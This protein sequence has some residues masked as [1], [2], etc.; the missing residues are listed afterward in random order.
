MATLAAVVD[1]VVMLEEAV[2]LAAM[3]EPDENWE[4]VLGAEAEGPTVGL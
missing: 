1:L 4:G 2:G 3:R